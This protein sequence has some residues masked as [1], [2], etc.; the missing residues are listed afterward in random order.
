MARY[1]QTYDCLSVCVCVCVCVCVSVCE[2]ESESESERERERQRVPVKVTYSN[3]FLWVGCQGS[4]F[5]NH[6]CSKKKKEQLV[7]KYDACTQTN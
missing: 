6:I 1:H 3:M 7:F 4:D 2:S 5:Q